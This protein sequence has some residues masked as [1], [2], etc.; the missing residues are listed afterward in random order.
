MAARHAVP[1][2]KLDIFARDDKLVARM[3]CQ[4]LWWMEGPEDNLVSWT[5]SLLFALVYVF[6][7]HANS[8]DGSEFNDISLCIIDTTKFAA[9]TFLQDLDLIK[10]YVSHDADLRKLEEI[11]LDKYYFGEYLSQGALEIQDK[12]E[13][14]PASAMIEHGL[15][16]LRPDFKSFASWPKMKRPPWANPVLSLREKVG[17]MDEEKLLALVTIAGLFGPRWKLPMAANLAS[18]LGTSEDIV[19][20]FVDLHWTGLSS[21]ALPY[22]R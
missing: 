12:C 2:S 7:L 15:L 9:G 11:R 10:A 3:L 6:H 4:H 17:G 16:T 8:R 18:C 22:M 21:V 1:N 20:S 13:I 19:R 5:S 14:V